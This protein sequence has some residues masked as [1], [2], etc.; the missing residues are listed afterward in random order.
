MLLCPNGFEDTEEDNCQ[1]SYPRNIREGEDKA[2]RNA[3]K[4]AMSVINY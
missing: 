3:F 4:R 2:K 1:S